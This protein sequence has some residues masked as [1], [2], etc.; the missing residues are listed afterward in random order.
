MLTED[1]VYE[2]YHI[3]KGTVVFALEWYV[4]HAV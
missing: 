1:D 4:S 2:G 3:A